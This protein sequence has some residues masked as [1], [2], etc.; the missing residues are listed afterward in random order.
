VDGGATWRGVSV[1]GAAD[2]DFRGIH[3]FDPKTAI[4]MS[5]GTGAK[6]RLYKTT[7]SGQTWKLLYTN[8]DPKG[9]FDAIAFW[10][11]RHGILLGDP[12]HGHFVVLTTQDG[13]ENWEERKTPIALLGEGAFAASNTALFTIGAREAWFGTGGRGGAR[14]FHTL[15]GG[16]TWTVEATPIHS[17]NE[18]AGIFS[19]GFSDPLHGIAVGGDHTQPASSVNTIAVT[20]DGGK[21]WTVPFSRPNGYRSAVVYL[22]DQ[23]LWI[24]AGTSGSDASA[25]GGLTWK[26]FD[27]RPL[28]AMSF[29]LS[30]AGWAVGPDGAIMRFST[31]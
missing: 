3:A 25:D 27:Q 10:D 6:S 17:D 8:P 24:A 22:P 12:V 21:K 14:V 4:L 23:K 30:Y 9:F 5:A 19:L 1:P 13:G 16:K 15:D 26:R 2:L 31:E 29:V 28:N 7:D 11:A 20:S 18:N